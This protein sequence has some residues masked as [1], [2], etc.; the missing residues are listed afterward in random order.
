MSDL[1]LTKQLILVSGAPGVGKS[2]IAT[3]LAKEL[4]FALITKDHI[5]EV[6]FDSFE[7]PAGDLVFS[8]RIGSAAMNVLWSLAALS[9]RVV[10][11]A[12]F[13]PHSEYEQGRLRSFRCPVVEVHCTCP[14]E[15][16][17]RRFE[18]RAAAERH[19]PAHPLAKFSEEWF[20]EY[21]RPMGAGSLIEV[22]VLQ[23]V[24]V[25]ALVEKVRSLLA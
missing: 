16:L 19:H 3:P 9:P 22:D 11:D 24:D 23:A 15:D 17:R 7:G 12:N 5:K 2:T 6:L 13:R 20:A 10:L 14:P 8:R 18:H 1:Q 21:D 4:G 25:A